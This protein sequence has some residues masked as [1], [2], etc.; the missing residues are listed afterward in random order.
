MSLQKADLRRAS[1]IARPGHDCGSLGGK[2]VAVSSHRGLAAVTAMAL[3]ACAGS[4][5]RGLPPFSPHLNGQALWRI[6]HEQ[7]VQDERVHGDPSPCVVVNLSA[8]EARG[9]ALLKDRVGI[10]QH[11]L[12]PTARVTGM[13]DPLLLESGAV[14]Y[15]AEAWALRRYVAALQPART[16]RAP[17]SIAVNSRY[18][19]SQDQLHLHIDCVAPDVAAALRPLPRSGRLGW[20]ART[21][22]L[23]RRHYALRWLPAR[24][25]AAVSPFKLLAKEVRGSRPAMGAYTIV[26]IGDDEPSAPGFWLLADRAEPLAADWASGETLQDHTCGVG[27]PQTNPRP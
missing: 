16:S 6:V 7:C 8:G 23:M 17:L 3:S 19:R 15:F 5:P 9:F 24:D 12:I 20:A 21:V 25:L 2:A 14:N 13:E 26:L 4:A 11:L 27:S 10:A 1:T 22:V 18:G